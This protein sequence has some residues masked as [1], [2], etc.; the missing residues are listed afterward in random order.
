MDA[1]E[2]A[3]IRNIWQ[4]LAELRGAMM[5]MQTQMMTATTMWAGGLDG[6]GQRF[7]ALQR[8]M[9]R[10]REAILGRLGAMEEELSAMNDRVMK[11][12]EKMDKMNTTVT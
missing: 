8:H 12:E 6:I 10:M 7:D 11:I 4:Q 5:Q 2:I 3:M 9:Q 1:A